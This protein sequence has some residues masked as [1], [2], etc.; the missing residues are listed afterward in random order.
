MRLLNACVSNYLV[1]N[2]MGA[3]QK[4]KAV[5]LGR[6]IRGSSLLSRHT[7]KVF[8]YIESYI[9]VYVNCALF[10]YCLIGCLIG[11]ILLKSLAYFKKGDA[12]GIWWDDKV[13]RTQILKA[14]KY[15][16]VLLPPTLRDIL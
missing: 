1:I 11:Y 7:L 8:S 12:N 4:R 15:G 13:E 2:M 10:V 5:F 9:L 14:S 16:P 3:C 6:S